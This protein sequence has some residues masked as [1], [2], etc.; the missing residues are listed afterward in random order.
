MSSSRRDGVSMPGS[1]QQKE[2]FPGISHGD[3]WYQ[4]EHFEV[5]AD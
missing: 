4:R 3:D 2:P 5:S 1:E